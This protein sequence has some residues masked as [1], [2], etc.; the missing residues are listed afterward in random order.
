MRPCNT[1]VRVEY[2]EP[3]VRWDLITGSGNNPYAGLDRFGRVVDCLWRYYGSGAADRE[4]VKYGYSRAG[5]RTWRQNT[6]AAGGNDELYRYDGLQ[7]LVDMARGTLAAQKDRLTDATF[8]QDWGLDAAGNWSRFDQL[9]VSNPAENLGQ[10]RAGNRANEITAISQRYGAVW[11]TPG[12]DRAGNMTMIPRPATPTTAFTADYDAWN[13]LVSLAGTATYRYDGLNRRV[14]KLVGS[15]TRHFYYTTRWQVVEERLGTT[16]ATADAQRQFVWGLR[17]LDDL[18]LR[19]RD[20]D[21]DGT[22]DERLYPLQDA[23]WNVT[24]LAD[25][26]GAVQERYRY[27]PLRPAHR[28]RCRLHRPH[29]VGLRLGDALRRVPVGWRVEFLSSAES[30][31]PFAGRHLADKRPGGAVGPKRLLLR[32]RHTVDRHRQYWP[33]GPSGPVHRF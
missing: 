20:T 4:R 21:A 7:R 9:D 22:L 13:R 30:V 14:T 29:H 27:T 28:A 12:Y 11:F 6:V 17:Y 24:A 33:C 32:R 5:S 19:D 25:T 8:A 16:P 23:N 18:V 26:A 1:P 2:G 15:V 31:P 3:Q 10:E